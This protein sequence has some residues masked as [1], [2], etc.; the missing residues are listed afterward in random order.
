MF[1]GKSIIIFVLLVALLTVLPV[2]AEDNVTSQALSVDDANQTCVEDS[3]GSSDVDEDNLASADVEELLAD[4]N[5][6]YQRVATKMYADKFSQNAVDS[7]AGEKG[8]YFSVLLTNQN[9][10]PLPNKTVIIGWNGQSFNVI[11]NDVGY[12][13]LQVNIAKAD[14]YTFAYAFLGDNSYDGCMDVSTVKI[15]KKSTSIT[16]NAKTFKSKAKT[17][18]YTVTLKTVK[19][20]NGKIYLSAG[21]KITLKLKGKTYTAKTNAQGKATF[22]LKITKKG[23]F[24][25]TIKYAGDSTY[26]ASS[27]TKYITIK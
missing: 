8:G 6:S 18:K 12:A 9:G 15:T 17:K 5:V 10:K 26:K 7:K 14:T 13:V 11:T 4:G 27:K 25:A 22:K 16:A 24:K 2:C 23:K 20:K 3:L 19:S 1:K 21:K